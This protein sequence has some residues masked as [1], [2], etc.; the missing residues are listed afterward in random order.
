MQENPIWY[1]QG[2]N[3]QSE[4]G[5]L[6]QGEAPVL[7]I[8]VDPAGKEGPLEGSKWGYDTANVGGS[9]FQC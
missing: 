7:S 5:E 9:C 6:K 8:R 4:M 1:Y 3:H 2:V